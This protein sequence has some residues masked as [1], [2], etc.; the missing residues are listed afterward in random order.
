MIW[1]PL[2]RR[3]GKK[4]IGARR[5]RPGRNICLEECALRQALARLA[6]HVR[7]GIE[8]DHFRFRITSDQKLG[9]IARTA[10]EIKYKSR[11]SQRHLRQ[12]IARRARA[13]ILEFQVLPRTPIFHDLRSPSRLVCH[14]LFIRRGWHVRAT[15]SLPW[16]PMP[17]SDPRRAACT[18]PAPRTA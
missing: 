16:Q 4:E 11:I 17:S 18:P 14:P 9:G 8:T 6:Q 1:N 13:F 10:A 15:Q 3:I 5:S 2:E 12:E 7:R